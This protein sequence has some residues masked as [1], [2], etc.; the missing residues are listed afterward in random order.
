MTDKEQLLKFLNDCEIPYRDHGNSV[1]ITAGHGP[2]KVEGYSGFFAEYEF[3]SDGSF[4]SMA[5][6]E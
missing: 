4:K 5:I 1:Y 2:D 6:A 3:N